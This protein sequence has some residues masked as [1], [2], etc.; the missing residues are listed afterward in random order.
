[1]EHL[2]EFCNS[3]NQI[4]KVRS[5]IRHGNVMRVAEEMELSHQTISSTLRTLRRRAA[6]AGVAPESDMN[7]RVAEGFNVKG[8]STL[9]DKDGNPKIQWVKT[10]AKGQSPAE[11]A[12]GFNEYL[13]DFKPMVYNRPSSV[14]EDLLVVYPM[15]DPHI[16]MYAEED[17]SGDNSNLEIACSDLRK[18]TQYLVERSPNA[19]TAIILNLGDFFHSDNSSNRTARAGNALDVDGMWSN[20]LKTGIDL[21]CEL[22]TSALGK[23]ENVI[24][25]NII[26]NHDDHSSIFIGL[27]LNK[28][29]RN[30]PRVSVDL[31]ACKYW[32]YQFGSVLIGSTHGDTAKPT[33]LPEI[34][35]ADKPKE[36]GSSHYRYWYTGHIHSRNVIEF[37]GCVWESFRTLSTGDSWHHG[38]GYRSG[39]EMCSIL[40]HKDFGE[41]GRNT[42]SIKMINSNTL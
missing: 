37:S 28:Y 6:A 41:V 9:Y 16:G 7:H 13:A 3:Q 11:I 2:L 30:E 40:L 20:I 4:D 21:M 8:T 22:V 24:V 32:Y 42:A 38:A 15:G 17:I 27:A 33:K 14:E 19:K 34:M 12:D 23:H 26:G 1:M 31:S 39:R 36:W 35:A 25:K 5:Y 10:Y 18:A 29:F